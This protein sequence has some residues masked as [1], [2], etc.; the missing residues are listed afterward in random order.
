MNKA[1]VSIWMVHMFDLEPVQDNRWYQINK[2]WNICPNRKGYIFN[3]LK[4]AFHMD[5]LSM[6]SDSEQVGYYQSMIN[7]EGLWEGVDRIFDKLYQ[8]ACRIVYM[9]EKHMQ[10]RMGRR[11]VSKDYAERDKELLECITPKR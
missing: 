2:S 5:W 6:C 3:H 9:L 7:L 4:T 10:S 11:T 1:V 8:N